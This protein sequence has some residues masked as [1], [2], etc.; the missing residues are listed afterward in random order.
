MP[1]HKKNLH[2]QLEVRLTVEIVFFPS[3]Q[4]RQVHQSSI[5]DTYLTVRD[6]VLRLGF[7]VFMVPLAELPVFFLSNE[8]KTHFG[9]QRIL[10]NNLK[11]LPFGPPLPGIAA[12]LS[13]VFVL[14]TCLLLHLCIRCIKKCTKRTTIVRSSFSLSNTESLPSYIDATKHDPPSYIETSKKHDLPPVYVSDYIVN[15]SLTST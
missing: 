15:T 3:Y 5:K 9:L 2:F 1:F 14:V 8:P 10:S 12:V 6:T 4:A 11:R 13:V 7:Y